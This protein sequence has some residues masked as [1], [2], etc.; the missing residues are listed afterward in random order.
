MYP[1]VLLNNILRDNIHI[2]EENLVYDHSAAF[3]LK[4][5]DRLDLVWETDYLL[6]KFNFSNTCRTVILYREEGAVRF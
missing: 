5:N 2:S 4:I 6:S 1:N 3:S